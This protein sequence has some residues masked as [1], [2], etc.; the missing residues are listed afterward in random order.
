M[1]L[2]LSNSSDLISFLG[3]YLV[4]IRRLISEA[5]YEEIAQANLVCFDN[6][7]LSLA[8]S[9]LRIKAQINHEHKMCHI[10]HKIVMV[11]CVAL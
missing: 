11:V 7:P 5:C 2:I 4:F 1:C 8:E 9:I 10:E 6:I 3:L